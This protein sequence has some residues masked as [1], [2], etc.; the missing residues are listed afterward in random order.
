ML[1]NTLT[2]PGEHSVLEGYWTSTRFVTP[3]P[4]FKQEFNW[5]GTLRT[6]PDHSYDSCAWGF[7]YMS[8][9]RYT[10]STYLRMYSTSLYRYE[11]HGSVV[12]DPQSGYCIRPVVYLQKNILT[13]G[14]DANG[15]WILN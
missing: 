4:A 6:E 1:S 11:A 7:Q 3:S 14:K 15:A 13:S 8:I 12:Y 9:N 2:E 5:D 10:S